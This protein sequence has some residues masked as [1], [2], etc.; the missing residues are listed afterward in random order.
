MK[1][2]EKALLAISVLTLVFTMVTSFGQLRIWNGNYGAD[3]AISQ[4]ES[5]KDRRDLKKK[6]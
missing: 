6:K 4:V 5:R 3:Y 1:G 2:L